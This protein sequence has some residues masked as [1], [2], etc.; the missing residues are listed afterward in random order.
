MEDRTFAIRDNRQAGWWWANNDVI[1]VYGQELGTHGIA[2]YCVLARHAN[3]RSQQC[4]P[5][6]RR[7]AELIGTSPRHVTAALRRLE[8]AGLVQIKT[9][10]G[11]GNVYTLVNPGGGGGAAPEA[12]AEAV[13]APATPV[14]APVTP[15]LPERSQNKTH[16]NQTQNNTSTGVVSYSQ[17]LRKALADLGMTTAGVMAVEANW[18]EQQIARAV[19]WVRKLPEVSNPAGYLLS[20]AKTGRDPNGFVPPTH[21]ERVAQHEA[22]QRTDTAAG[23]W[24]RDRQ[25]CSGHYT[26]CSVCSFGDRES[27]PRGED[28]EITANP[29]P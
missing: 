1:D 27:P 29:P 6:V 12:A 8:A 10:A 20:L 17:N 11:H 4:W 16:T 25:P 15:V 5:G 9:C 13:T 23:C 21:A 19:D 18:S 7:I 26:W 3:N 24:E 14:T 22:A 2:V 28:D